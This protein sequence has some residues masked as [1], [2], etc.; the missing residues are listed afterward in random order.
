MAAAGLASSLVA[1]TV[2]APV[3]AAAKAWCRSQWGHRLPIGGQLIALAQDSPRRSD[4]GPT[5][6][7]V[8]QRYAFAPTHC[9]VHAAG[10]RECSHTIAA[11]A[12]PVIEGARTDADARIVAR[13]A[14]RQI[15]RMNG[16]SVPGALK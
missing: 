5:P 16:V 4:A 6:E 14:I 2:R 1:A 11:Q 12:G 15:A 13:E 10:D 7:A 8:I 9:P 3:L